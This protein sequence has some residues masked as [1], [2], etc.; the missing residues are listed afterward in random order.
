MPVRSR[1]FTVVALLFL[2]LC[3]PILAA[4]EVDLENARSSTDWPQFRGPERNGLSSERGLLPSWPENGPRELWRR[5]L[6]AGFSGLSVVGNQLYTLISDGQ[7]DAR[8][9][10][11]VAIDSSSGNEIWRR[12]LGEVFVD[13]FGDGPRST[14]TVDGQ[15][16]FVLGSYGNLAA[17]ASADGEV[18]WQVDLRQAYAAEVPLWGFSSSPLVIGDRLVVQIGGGDNLALGIFDRATGKE[19]HTLLDGGA[20][21]NSPIILRQ[22]SKDLV[23][24]ARGNRVVAVDPTVGKIVWEHPWTEKGGAI[25]MPL[26]VP[27]DGLFLSA[28]G[29]VGAVLLSLRQTDAGMVVESRWA[30]RVMKNHFSSSVTHGGLI[31]GFDNATLKCIRS[32]D[33]EQK[34]A[35]RGFGKGS[36]IVSEGR[37]FV[38]SDR[39]LLVVVDTTSEDYRELGRVQAL[40]GKAW[41]APTLAAGRLYLRSGQ[42][43]VAYELG[44]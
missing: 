37:L 25:S 29:D 4:A 18:L 34:W 42:E 3:S 21:Y 39:G 12:Q 19:L 1:G 23:V 22:G 30:S 36:L 13:E 32:S 20:S 9:E 6:G 5:P 11:A 26:A 17:L 16:V 31:Y 41:T 24:L 27:P 14:P 43:M 35:K 10:F 8:Y 44:S 7:E 33:G 15:R 38:L 40:E 28:S 2:L